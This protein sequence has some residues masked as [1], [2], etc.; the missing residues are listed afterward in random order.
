MSV[1]VEKGLRIG[2]VATL[3]KTFTKQKGT[4][5]EKMFLSSNDN[6][7][8][9]IRLPEFHL[10]GRH[11]RHH[12]DRKTCIKNNSQESRKSGDPNLCKSM[13]SSLSVMPVAID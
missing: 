7:S 4:S 10:L 12:F 2:V 13:K 8:S 11:L 5:P 9:R 1:N 6:V 3:K